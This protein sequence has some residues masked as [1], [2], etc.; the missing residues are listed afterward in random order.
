MAALLSIIP[1]QALSIELDLSFDAGARADGDIHAI[2][3]LDDGRI[4][5]AGE[6]TTID[7]VPRPYVARL[8]PDGAV[9]F[10]FNLRIGPSS[11][12]FAV[13]LQE[14]GGI[15]IGGLF[16][17]VGGVARP[18]LARLLGDGSFDSKF[19]TNS[20]F[21]G[22]VRALALQPDGR[23]LVGGEFTDVGGRSRNRIA[24]LLA[25]GTL[26]ETFDPGEGANGTLRA[27]ALQPD[28][29]VIIGGRFTAYG[30]TDRGR[31]ARVLETGAL[32]PDFDSGT[33]ADRQVRALGLLPDGRIYVGGEFEIFN[34]TNR[35][36]IARLF[37]NGGLD[38]GFEPEDM[39]SDEVQT[40]A[41]E[42][43][44]HVWIGGMFQS[45]GGQF[46]PWLA[47]L[48]ASGSAAPEV[49]TVLSE[50]LPG[51]E[52]HALLRQRD[53]LMIVAGEFRKVNSFT[54]QRLA[55][56][57]PSETPAL[58]RIQSSGTITGNA[59][60]GSQLLFSIERV[61]PTGTQIS[62]EYSTVDGTAKSGLDYASQ[63]GIATFAPGEVRK[64][65]AISL[66]PD[67][68]FDPGE[69]F[70][71]ELRS[72][73]RAQLGVPSVA[74]AE[75]VEASP[76]IQF[77]SGS[78]ACAEAPHFQTTENQPM[79]IGVRRENL[80]DFPNLV[81]SVQYE[82]TPGTA[83]H[84][85]DF[86]GAL[87]GTLE[88]P[89]G[90]R[91]LYIPLT[92]V[93]DGL[94]E[95]AKT[96]SV[97]LVS[98]NGAVLNTS[99]VTTVTIL[100]DDGPVTW[101]APRWTVSE[102]RASAEVEIR[103]NDNGPTAITVGYE[104][105]SGSANAGEDFVA[106]A[107]SVT[108]EPL[109]RSKTVTVSP[110]D[111]CRIE[112][113]EAVSLTLVSVQGGSALSDEREAVLVL[114]DNERAGTF[115]PE[116]EIGTELGH[117]LNAPLALDKAG[118]VLVAN[119]RRSSSAEGEIIRFLPDWR[120]DEGFVATNWPYRP[121]AG[122]FA[123]SVVVEQ[124]RVQPDGSI[125]T[126]FRRD[127]F[128]PDDQRSSNH[129]V[130]FLANG[131]LDEAFRVDDRVVYPPGVW[132]AGGSIHIET[133]SDG[134]IL[135]TGSAKD[136]S[137]GVISSGLVR[138][139]P[140]GSLDD[141]FRADLSVPFVWDN[142]QIAA[143]KVMSDGRVVL[144]GRFLLG[145]TNFS[146]VLRLT[147]SGDFDPS[148]VP[149]PCQYRALNG[150]F[151]ASMP[152]SLVVQRDGRIVLG[153]DF[154]RVSGSSRR[155]LARLLDDGTVDSDFDPVVG[156]NEDTDATV[157]QVFLDERERI[158]ATGPLASALAGP[159]QK[160]IR[161]LP[162]GTVDPQF[163]MN[164]VA[165]LPSL[166]EVLLLPDHKLLTGWAYE[167]LRLVNGDPSPRI[168]VNRMP[169]G[170]LTFS[171]STIA[172]DSYSLER[173]ADFKLWIELEKKIAAECAM[174]FQVPSVSATSFYRVVRRPTP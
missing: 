101:G 111:D 83:V 157:N 126:A 130:R 9:D 65:I 174:D 100:D 125:V 10:S 82:I 144:S 43:D 97:R 77:T 84:G 72:P 145:G 94:P 151:V 121:A 79:W 165:L 2:A 110:L 95:P 136:S 57:I 114:L 27:L 155:G 8:H 96:L 104:V 140:D 91:D 21:N 3:Q 61:G 34:G 164:D 64:E 116:F 159:T 14:D 88:F 42:P 52:V 75:I 86:L 20:F 19:N 135:A 99:N 73:Q 158:I 24:R 25:D 122:F 48:N 147:Q 70:T 123:S 108:F 149:A 12:V 167:G 142:P 117:Q 170:G 56:L 36:S 119:A 128:G 7:D 13:V 87:Q 132:L 1:I 172:G 103:R 139:Q 71:L 173:S 18:Y 120:I 68:V 54:R 162:T 60:E 105:T 90:V 38:L 63:S 138:L 150:S 148:F 74:R 39:A 129:V 171:T 106:A 146:G 47:H 28:G 29:K 161:L 26:D 109:E 15:V 166:V 134:R 67:L 141:S 33:G 23:I 44:G 113:D 98:A 37:P 45:V 137:G 22:A 11:S 69:V 153:G 92:L 156:V 40:L 107:G 154:A 17:S 124:L 59:T 4:I 41:V 131:S 46:G 127:F 66:L 115:D 169:G 58:V 50:N 35:S 168:S 31:V 55:R 160:M 5:V 112:P 6:F 80:A 89:T 30:G 78:Y 32:D 16:T 76:V 143:L 152:S 163:R 133:Q 49:T 85:Q 93:N 81:S 118:R 102:R 62:V 51:D 53:G